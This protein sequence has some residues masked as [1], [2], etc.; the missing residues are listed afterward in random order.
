MKTMHANNGIA[1]TR[2]LRLFNAPTVEGPGVKITVR[3]DLLAWWLSLV[4]VLFV[5]SSTWAIGRQSYITNAF[6]KA[7]FPLSSSRHA[8][9]L[10]VSSKDYPGV[11]RALNDLK[12]DIGRVTGVEPAVMF[13]GQSIP[14]EVLIV[15][16]IGKSP[17]IDQLVH[18]KKLDVKDIAGKWETYVLQTIEHPIPG[19]DK[20]LIIAGSDKR[21]TIY[22]IYDLSEH[23]GVSPWYWWADVPV[24]RQQKLFVIPGRYTQGPPAVKYR[25]IFI[26]D[27][28]PAFSGWAK[29][30]FGGINSRVYT[31]MFELI[32]RLK[33]NYLWPA[34]WDNAFN[35]DDSLDRPLADEYGI[36]MGTSHHEPMDRAQKEWQRYG[37]GAW[38]YTTNGEELRAFWRK[39][40]ENMGNAETIVTMGMRGDG[41]MPMEAGTNI[42]LLEKIIADQRTILTEVTGKKP[43]EIPQLWALYTEVQKYYDEGMRVPDDITLLFCDDNYGN[44]RRLPD[45]NAP[46][47]SGG[48]G[49]Y[50]HFDFNGG[51]WSYK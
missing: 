18:E 32:L 25:G 27:E 39:G 37:K 8:T 14:R 38:N 28:A 42:A 29:A 22:G 26:N 45:L 6:D 23:I 35:D 44:L 15:G 12:T 9:T 47:R 48:F 13:D 41:D 36:V 49:L 50:Y 31:K 21:G 34:M 2:V 46:R 17:I 20:A 7:Y 24:Q 43:E 10:L 19:V 11:R 40:I 5:P 33:G 4:M 16:T 30:K 51:P 1:V 3:G